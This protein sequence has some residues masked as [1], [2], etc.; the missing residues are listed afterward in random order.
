L[1]SSAWKKVRRPRPHS[2]SPTPLPVDDFQDLREDGDEDVMDQEE[3]ALFQAACLDA[4]GIPFKFV[5][6]W[7]DELLVEVRVVAQER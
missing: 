5:F 2:A 7:K 3:A 4:L 6:V 1:G